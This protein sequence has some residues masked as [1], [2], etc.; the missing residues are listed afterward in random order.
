MSFRQARALSDRSAAAVKHT[1]RAI[2]EPPPPGSS[3]ERLMTSCRRP[4]VLIVSWEYPPLVEGGLARH[5]GQLSRRLAATG[6]D[7]HVLT[8]GSLGAPVEEDLDGVHVHRTPVSAWPAEPG[9]FVAWVGRMN[10]RLLAAGAA[11]AE[12]V[13][14]DLIHGHDWLVGD[15]AKG[16]AD[17]LERP[18]VMTIHAT[19]YGRHQGWIVGQPQTR[20][21]L[22][23]QRIVDRA[24]RVIACSEFMAGHI[25]DVFGVGESRITVIP[26]GVDP[27]DLVA[28]EP[29][30]LARLRGR[31]A[32]PDQPLVLMVGRLVYEK[33]FQVG[34]DALRQLIALRPGLR[35]VVAGSGIHAGEL[36]AQAERLGLD[37]HGSFV[38]WVGDDLLG[39]L[40]RIADVCV[41]PSIFEPAG[42]VALEAM[43]CGCPCVVA[44]TG[45]LREA[46]C[47]GRTGLRF[48]VRDPGSLASM[49]D[50]VLGLR[51]LREAVVRAGRE[52]VASFDWRSTAGATAEVYRGLLAAPWVPGRWR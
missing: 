40:Y 35:F 42:L 7:V 11:L 37:Q 39:S 23:E 15:A 22:A 43:A 26:N 50:L 34:L 5:V 44:D 38:G 8:R 6:L 31:F 12:R 30:A 32:A 14:F 16:L 33:G 48:A 18:L 28:A 1:A 13:E 20:I 47:H 19:E 52:H 17:R 25:A 4:A 2:D 24:D 27:A 21:H 10:S 3:P 46:V 41:I 51:R 9:R 49:V 36:K 29:A 45:G